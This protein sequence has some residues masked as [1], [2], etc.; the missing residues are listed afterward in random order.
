M[1]SILHSF[2]CGFTEMSAYEALVRLAEQFEAADIMEALKEI[3][4]ASF[5]DYIYIANPSKGDY[6]QW[7]E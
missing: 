5:E 6:S 7:D 4:P 1:S 3:D 2:T